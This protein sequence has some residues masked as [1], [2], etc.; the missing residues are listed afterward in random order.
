MRLSK[1]SIWLIVTVAT[2]AIV[3]AYAAHELFWRNTHANSTNELG[4]TLTQESLV[5]LRRDTGTAQEYEAALKEYL[6]VLDQLQSANPNSP[7]TIVFRRSKSIVL[8]RLAMLVEK[9]GANAD[10]ARYMDAAVR[11]CLAA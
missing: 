1:R 3:V 6:I 8:G 2:A 5:N 9:R 4:I 10:A 11:E 7:N